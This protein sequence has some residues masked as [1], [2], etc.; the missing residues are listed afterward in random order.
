[1]N[2]GGLKEM[3][4]NQLRC[5]TRNEGGPLEAVLQGKASN[6]RELRRIKAWV[7]SV[8]EKVRKTASCE[9]QEGERK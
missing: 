7:V 1:M 8:T 2:V 3:E 9:D 5:C 4:L 6:N